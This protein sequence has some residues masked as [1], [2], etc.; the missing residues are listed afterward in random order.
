MPSRRALFAFLATSIFAA[1][2]LACGPSGPLVSPLLAAVVAIP[3]A[4]FASVVL[5]LFARRWNLGLRGWLRTS[6]AS[7]GASALAAG[8]ASGVLMA[9][10]QSL[11]DSAQIAV[12]LSS[13]VVG[14]VAYVAWIRSRRNLRDRAAHAEADDA[15]DAA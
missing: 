11:G 8:I 13:P 9:V 5:G 12:L 7:Y 4:L 1:P 2:A 10:D 15:P 6:V 3:P 14:T